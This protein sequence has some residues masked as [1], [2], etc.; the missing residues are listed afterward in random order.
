MKAAAAAY[1]NA[2]HV[3][4]LPAGPSG[5]LLVQSRVHGISH[6]AFLFVISLLWSQADAV[7]KHQT[8]VIVSI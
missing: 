1:I 3:G 2:A 6:K 7:G 5:P 4:F 8:H